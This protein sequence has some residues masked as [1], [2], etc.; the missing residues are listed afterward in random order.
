ML[1]KIAS[2]R[3]VS[4]PA[5]ASDVIEVGPG[6]HLELAEVPDGCIS[7]AFYALCRESRACSPW[8]VSRYRW[9]LLLGLS[10]WVIS[11]SLAS[12][13]GCR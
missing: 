4:F 2:R 7:Q 12:S 3:Q 13:P 6:D 11:T 1:V 8:A 5:R 9:V 10:G